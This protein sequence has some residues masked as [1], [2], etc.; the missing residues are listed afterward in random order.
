[1]VKSG[2]KYS[3]PTP[4]ESTI[5]GP[6]GVGSVAMA[7][8]ADV[9]VESAC[10]ETVSAGEP[11]ICACAGVGT[12][13]PTNNIRMKRASEAVKVRNMGFNPPFAQQVNQVFSTSIRQV[14]LIVKACERPHLQAI[15]HTNGAPRVPRSG[16]Y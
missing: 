8:G 16:K 5:D 2:E 13:A 1:M 15:I 12:V 9:D 11:P 7:A 4:D 6:L 14:V 10:A 3:V